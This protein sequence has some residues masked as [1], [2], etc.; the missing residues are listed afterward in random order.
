M[1]LNRLCGSGMH[2]IVN[3]ARTII[4]VERRK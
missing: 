2:A 3:A 4:K 1:R